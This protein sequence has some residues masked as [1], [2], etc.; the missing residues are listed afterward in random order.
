MPSS[1]GQRSPRTPKALVAGA[2]AAISVALVL[3]QS[4]TAVAIL[5]LDGLPAAAL[6]AVIALAGTW[7]ASCLKLADAPIRWQLLIGSG[8][9]LGVTSALVLVLGVCGLLDRFIWLVILL[10]LAAAALGAVVRLRRLSGDE[11]QDTSEGAGRLVWLWL[12]SCPFIAIA[13]LVCVV[14]P[15]FLWAEE[16]AGYDVLEYHLQLPKEYFQSGSIAYTPHNVYGSFPANAEM[17]YLLCMIVRDDVYAGAGSAKTLNA[18]LAGLFVFAAYV[19]GRETGAKTGVVTGVAASGIGW[20]TYLSGV[21]YVENAMLLF[22]MIA[23]AALIRAGRPAVNARGQWLL[24]AGLMCGFACG[25]KY[26]A[27]ILVALPLVGAA[28]LLPAR[29]LALRARG[30]GV[31]VLGCLAGFSPWLIKNSAMTGNPVFPLANSVFRAFPEGWGQ[32]E[33]R[34]FALSHRPEPEY[35]SLGGRIAAVWARLP[36]DPLERF[37]RMPWLLAAVPLCTV[38]LKRRDVMMMLVLLVQLG[39]WMFATHLYARFAVPMAVPL[40][41]LAGRSFRYAASEGRFGV[42]AVLIAGMLYSGFTTAR[43]Y[44]QHLYHEGTK[45]PL[46]GAD[47]YFLQGFGGGHEHLSVINSELPADA[48]VLMIGDAR[49][50]YFQR[51]VDYT[52]VFNRSPFIEA[53]RASSGA[54]EIIAWLRHRDYTHVLVNWAEIHRLRRSLYGFPEVIRPELFERLAAGGLRPMEVFSTGDPPRPYA[55][56]YRVPVN[57]QNLRR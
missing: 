48:H 27:A 16:G 26:T 7:A 18:L 44:A 30:G 35:S 37:G 53:V 9:G 54:H 22:A 40:A 15:G 24:L 10:A 29:S 14:P 47:T 25:C 8:V 49:A 51:P 46:E 50:F 6:L 39:F 56:L 21:A 41:I 5:L 38:Y 43:L 20:L 4:W 13:L 42:S 23:G 55:V 36:G 45:L 31:V 1:Q 2:V 33:S 11:E 12:L 57:H 32:A 19:A 17:L 52:V 34:H 28:L 3:S